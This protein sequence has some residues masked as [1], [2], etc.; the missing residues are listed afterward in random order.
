MIR[1]EQKEDQNKTQEKI[2]NQNLTVVRRWSL[3]I[4]KMVEITNK[5]SSLKGKRF[6]IGMNPTK[7]IQK[8]LET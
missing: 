3:S 1:R 4:L 2:A 8:I 7:Y 6:R 5:K